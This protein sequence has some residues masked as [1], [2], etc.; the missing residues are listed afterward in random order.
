MISVSN[1][2][3]SSARMTQR[4]TLHNPSC[5]FFSSRRRHT[6]FDCDW[7]SDV[8]SSDLAAG[9][10]DGGAL[11]DQAL[12]GHGEVLEAGDGDADDAVVGHLEAA[13]GPH[14]D[15]AH[16]DGGERC[17]HDAVDGAAGGLVGL[18]HQAHAADLRRPQKMA[19]KARAMRGT[20]AMK[21]PRYAWSRRVAMTATRTATMRRPLFM[22]ASGRAL[23]RPPARRPSR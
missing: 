9:D 10:G 3:S 8:C 14:G 18:P 19:S 15:G 12:G 4:L 21:P 7:S 1:L 2:Q 6:S 23:P 5:F 22:P 20:K 13:Q 17:V 11:L 16:V